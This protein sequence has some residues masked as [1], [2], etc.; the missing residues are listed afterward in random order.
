ME[1]QQ[2]TPNDLTSVRLCYESFFLKLK[3]T[4]WMSK[5]TEIEQKFLLNGIPL[6]GEMPSIQ[7]SAHCLSLKDHK[8]PSVSIHDC[9]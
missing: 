1:C 4:E 5:T 8:L 9:K 7:G 2:C 3:N 6:L